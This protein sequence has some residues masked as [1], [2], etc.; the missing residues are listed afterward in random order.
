MFCT[1][2]FFSSSCFLKNMFSHERHIF[3]EW[4][5]S[6][7]G[8]YGYSFFQQATQ[9][10]WAFH[11]HSAV[12]AWLI[13]CLLT[14]TGSPC[15]FFPLC[16]NADTYPCISFYE[17]SLYMGTHSGIYNKLSESK[18]LIKLISVFSY[19]AENTF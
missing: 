19:S 13:I 16:S 11:C 15:L 5:L 14:G 17:S 7:P 4:V 12:L 10:I 9:L 8:L 6:L 18:R 2:S 3:S 1:H